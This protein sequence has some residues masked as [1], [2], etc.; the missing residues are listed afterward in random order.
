MG[1]NLQR[2]KNKKEAEQDL[3]K[4]RKNID[5]Y[6]R[7]Q[8]KKRSWRACVDCDYITCPISCRGIRDIERI[9]HL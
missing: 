1:K 9:R 4:L 5:N 2:Y 6:Y 3:K 7:K 8:G